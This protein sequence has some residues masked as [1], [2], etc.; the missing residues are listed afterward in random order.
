VTA[1]LRSC[2]LSQECLTVTTLRA[3]ERLPS[4]VVFYA[5]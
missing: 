4:E 3:A 5:P 2:T 1:R